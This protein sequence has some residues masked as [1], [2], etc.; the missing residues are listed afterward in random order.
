MNT[1]LD[2]KAVAKGAFVGGAAA[3]VL[4]VGLF[5]LG[6]AIGADYKTKDP[7][8]MGGLETLF[9]VQPFMNCIIAAAVSVGLL[10]ALSKLAP[11]KA[12]MIYLVVAAVVFLGEAYAPFWAFEDM[13]TIVMLE[14][15]HIPATVGIVGGIYMTAI[16]GR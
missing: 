4:D 6:S 16:N 5:F 7:A 1:P 2:L 9:F 13:K 14:I 10:A 15:M 12:W 11:A 3:G 8:A